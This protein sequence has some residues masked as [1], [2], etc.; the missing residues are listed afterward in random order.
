MPRIIDGTVVIATV[1]RRSDANWAVRNDDVNINIEEETSVAAIQRSVSTKTRKPAFSGRD[2]F[3]D[4]FPRERER[5]GEKDGERLPPPILVYAN[6]LTAIMRRL[7]S[8]SSPPSSSLLNPRSDNYA[9]GRSSFVR[10]SSFFWEK[11]E[12]FVRSFVSSCG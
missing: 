4:S 6:K 5:E 9:Q 8:S 12:T 2:N 1:G 7:S 11:Q 3:R 10:P